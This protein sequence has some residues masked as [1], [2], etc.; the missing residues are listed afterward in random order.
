MG[1]GSPP[2]WR[3]RETGSPPSWRPEGDGLVVHHGVRVGDGLC[4]IMA[5]ESGT[6]SPPSWRRSGRRCDPSWRRSVTARAKRPAPCRHRGS[7]RGRARPGGRGRVGQREVERPFQ[8]PVAGLSMATLMRPDDA[9]MTGPVRRTLAEQ[10]MS[11]RRRTV[12]VDPP[13]ARQLDLCDVTLSSESASRASS[14]PV[15]RVDGRSCLRAR[16]RRKPGTASDRPPWRHTSP[17][18]RS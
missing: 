5:S 1:S 17:C 8:S 11:R 12:E 9:P 16:A 3:P 13:F 2:S 6:G 14:W 4:S 18:P 7:R 15:V 10:R